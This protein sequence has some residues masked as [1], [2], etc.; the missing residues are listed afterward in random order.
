MCRKKH[1]FLRHFAIQDMYCYLSAND[2][3]KRS[4]IAAVEFTFA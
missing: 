4:S 2:L 1:I 3:L